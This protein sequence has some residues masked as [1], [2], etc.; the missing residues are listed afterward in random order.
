MRHQSLLHIIG[1]VL[2]ET[3]EIT[4]L[5]VVFSTGPA[6]EDGHRATALTGAANTSNDQHKK[7]LK[8]N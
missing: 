6:K 4:I 7:A 2:L 5:L 8:K 3:S 1:K